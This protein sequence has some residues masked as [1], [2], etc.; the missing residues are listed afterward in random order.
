VL[1]WHAS[2][3]ASPAEGHELWAANSKVALSDGESSIKNALR[4]Q[5]DDPLWRE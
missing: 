1:A 4:L 3:S 5:G 2:K